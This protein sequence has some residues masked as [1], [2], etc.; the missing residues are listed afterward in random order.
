MPI[1]RDEVA[2]L[3]RQ[4]IQAFES[5]R[6][7]Y[8]G[9]LTLFD[10]SVDGRQVFISMEAPESGGAHM[11][12]GLIQKVTWTL[13]TQSHSF[14]YIEDEERLGT[15]M[16]GRPYKR[17]DVDIDLDAASVEELQKLKDH[18]E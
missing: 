4:E 15:N 10:Y 6:I 9:D 12:P 17:M 14:E 3:I 5:G 1:L 13:G 7:S 8:S 18:L 11:M 16:A 2:D